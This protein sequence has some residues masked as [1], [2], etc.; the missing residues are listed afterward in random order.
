MEPPSACPSKIPTT[1][2]ADSRFPTP[3]ATSCS[4]VGQNRSRAER[5]RGR[6]ATIS[7]QPQI[8]SRKPNAS[9]CR[10]RSQ[11]LRAR[12]RSR[13]LQEVLYRSRIHHQLEQRSDRRT[14]DRRISFP[15][16]DLLCCRARGKFHDEPGRRRCGR[17]VG[18]HSAPRVHEKITRHHLQTPADAAVGNQGPLSERS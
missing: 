2:F 6:C 9:A 1:A 7:D 14:P 16:P 12:Q 8:S 17:L 4:S 10:N 18:A 11:T 5:L 13:T 3:T 15:A